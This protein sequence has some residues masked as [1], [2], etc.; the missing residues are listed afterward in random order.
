MASMMMMPSDVV[1]AHAEY[2]I[3]PTK[4]RLSKTLTGSAC[5]RERSGGL[6]DGGLLR[7]TG[8]GAEG[9]QRRSNSRVCSWPAA[10]RAAATRASTRFAR[11]DWPATPAEPS[12]AASAIADRNPHSRTVITPS[13]SPRQGGSL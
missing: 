10:V 4:Y 5:H 1:T 6:G 11:A 8:A 2:S 13:R 3:S 12:P 7:G 9:A